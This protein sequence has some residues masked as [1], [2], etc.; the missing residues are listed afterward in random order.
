MNEILFL[1]APLK[2][3]IWGGQYFKE[4]GR[5]N[6]EEDFGELWSASGHQEGLSLVTNGDLKGMSLADVY[7]KRPD[8]F[9]YPKS[10]VFPVLIKL[11]YARDA[12]SVQVHPDNEYAL[13]NENQLG[14]TEGWLILDAKDDSTIVLGHNANNYDQLKEYI[15]RDAYDELLN[16]IPVKKGQFF[17]I[18]AGTIHAI[19]KNITILEIQQSSDVT[20]RFY[21]YHRKDQN[22]HERELHVEKAC[23]VT[24]YDKPQFSTENVFLSKDIEKLLW[25]N[26][27][28]SV[29]LLNVEAE[30]CFTNPADYFIV[31]VVNGDFEI[32]NQKITLGDSFIITKA[33]EEVKILGEG[34]LIV[35]IPKNK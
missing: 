22:G 27:Y 26:D 34:R 32:Q 1:T 3:R 12:L 11:I 18:Y 10:D 15:N 33:A 20:Y 29:V 6:S 5:T 17:P 30:Y 19:G 7:Q 4:I 16:S 35:T 25:E 2:K 13:Q 8:L 9:N 21:D 24:T 23:A 14:K 28:F 31:S